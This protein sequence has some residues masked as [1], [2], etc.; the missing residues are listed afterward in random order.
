MWKLRDVSTC[1]NT[2]EDV[3][4]LNFSVKPVSLSVSNLVLS[5]AGNTF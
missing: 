2:P 4:D 3:K 5:L 1:Y